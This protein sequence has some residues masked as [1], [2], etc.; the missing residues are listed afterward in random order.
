VST[1][2]VRSATTTTTTA[3]GSTDVVNNSGSAIGSGWTVAGLE[4][5]IPASGGVMLDLGAGG[6]SLWFATGSGATYTSPAGEFSTLV[7]NSGGTY[8]RTFTNGFTVQFNSA[9]QETSALNLNGVGDNYAYNGAGSLKTITDNYSGVTTFAYTSGMLASITDPATHVTTFAHTGNGLSGV[10]LPDNSNWGYGYD[11]VGRLT[12]VT[13]PNSHTV[14]VGYDAAGRAATLTN[15]DS[16]TEAFSNSQET[17][18]V[19]AGSGTSA[20][21]AAPTLLSEVGASITDQLGH[22]TSLQPDWQGLGLTNVTIDPM[23]FTST[24]LRDGN[25]LPLVGV[26]PLNRMTQAVYDAQANVTQ[27]T[28]PDGTIASATYNTLAEPLTVTDPLGRVATKTYDGQGNMLTGVDPL[29]NT[30]TDTYSSTGQVLTITHPPINSGGTGPG[31]NPGLQSVQAVDTNTYDTALDLRMTSTVNNQMSSYGYNAAGHRTTVTDALNHTTTT[32]YDPMGR[33]LSL[34]DANNNQTTY[35]YDKVGN[36]TGVTDALNHTTTTAYDAMNRPTTVTDAR[37]GVTTTG[38]DLAGRVASITD[39]VTNKTSYTRDAD[40]RQTATT[41]P[42]HHSTTLT[43]DADGEVITQVDRDNRL[44]RYAHDPMGRVLTEAWI[45]GANA[46][47]NTITHTYDLD[48]ELTKLQD[49]SST[50]TYTYDKDGNALTASTAGTPGQPAVTLTSTYGPEHF[51]TGL[52]DG[53][54]TA[55]AIAYTY[56]AAQRLT[57]I[58][59]TYGGAAGPQVAFSY[60][61]A[62]NLTG[63]SRTIGGTGTAVASTLGYDPANRLTSIAHG[64]A[65][66]ATLASYTYGYDAA[67]RLATETNAEGTVNYSYDTTNQLTGATGSRSE[68]YTYDLNGN[69]TLSGYATGTNNQLAAGAGYTYSYDNEQNLISKTQ[70]ATSNVWTYT[71]D[72]RNRLTGVVERNAAGLPMVQGTYIYDTLDRRIGVSESAA[73]AVAD[74]GFE[75][76]AVG[77]GLAGFSAGA[78]WVDQSQPGGSAGIT[79]NHSPLT[80]GNPNAPQG[81]QVAFLYHQGGF[82]QPISGWA[83]GSYQ[84]RPC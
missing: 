61:A 34:T 37:S 19:A 46:A 38:Y 17:G 74:F 8:I 31:V 72:Y 28:E 81:A 42:F 79:G 43:L 65:G 68:A 2:D 16:T 70:T 18:L 41:D 53:L 80:S 33:V 60:D 27:T 78:A 69:R 77:N 76:V 5:I 14:T 9:G 22:I 29:N 66:G 35:A 84:I 67:D 48:G 40:G 3:T 71:W 15:P 20:S 45:D 55:G 59:G 50:L 51:L 73:P 12:G 52:A 62:D 6:K 4:R 58:A 63:Q 82:A 24:A 64:V 75:A 1:G 25:G 11:A 39:S 56:D 83:A 23:G 44:I 21:P 36:L 47:I 57:N 32:A 26:D 54:S 13:D 49:N 10:T 7:A 30:I